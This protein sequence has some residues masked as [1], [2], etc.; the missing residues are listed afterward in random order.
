MNTLGKC[1]FCMYVPLKKGCRHFSSCS[2]LRACLRI[3]NIGLGE[4]YFELYSNIFLL[5]YL[6]W[7]S[8]TK[9][10]F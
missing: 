7:T 8:I 6:Q 9:E 1:V 2:L 4:N 3:H 5:N 10:K